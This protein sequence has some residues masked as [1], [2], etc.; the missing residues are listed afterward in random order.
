MKRMQ[1]L[2][3][4]LNVHSFDHDTLIN[5]INHIRDIK[6]FGKI[7]LTQPMNE[8]KLLCIYIE[9]VGTLHSVDI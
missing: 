1:G 9:I 2:H 6:C 8:T 4:S 3:H 7:S 5:I